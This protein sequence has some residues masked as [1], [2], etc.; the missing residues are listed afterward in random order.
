MMLFVAQSTVTETQRGNRRTTKEGPSDL[1]FQ[2]FSL[3]KNRPDQGGGASRLQCPVPGATASMPPCKCSYSNCLPSDLSFF[4]WATELP[5]STLFLLLDHCVGPWSFAPEVLESDKFTLH[6]LPAPSVHERNFAAVLDRATDCRDDGYE[7]L[8]LHMAEAWPSMKILPA[9]PIRES[10]YADTRYFQA[11]GD[12]PLCLDAKTSVPTEGPPWNK[13]TRLGEVD[14]P[15]SK[16]VGSQ[17]VKENNKFNV[18]FS[19]FFQT[20]LPPPRPPVT[21]PKKYQPLPPE[22]ESSRWTPPQRHTFPEV[23]RGL[24]QISLKNLSEVLGTEK[25]HKE[26][27]QSLPP[28][29]CQSPA[30]YSPKE[31][32]LCYKNMSWRKP[33]PTRSDEKDI[34]HSE[35]Y[36]GECSR[37]AVEEA[38][39]KESKDGTFLVR[40][41]STRSRAEP[42][43]LVV[44]YGSKV[45]NVKI[46]FLER[47]Q[48][49]ALGTGLRGDE[50]ADPTVAPFLRLHDHGS[51]GL[52]EHQGHKPRAKLYQER[53]DPCPENQVPC[54]AL[55]CSR[56]TSEQVDPLL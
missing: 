38:L 25:D 48:Q 17:R 6:N 10:E 22:P 55:P 28:P 39:M 1:K 31:N 37:Q 33:F 26:S 18:C 5:A 16:D 3:P 8:K 23:H 54:L 36:I 41:C 56:V 46:R 21:L 12:T 14:K 49:F 30:S 27:T 44:F 2:N 32:S 9:R 4:L 51:P 20:P 45:Y 52:A 29:A 50:V 15:I 43:V 24:R 42:Y 13:W 19:F 40:D 47:N 7:D 34:R 35:W 11:M 53:A